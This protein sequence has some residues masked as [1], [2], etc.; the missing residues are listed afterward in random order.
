MALRAKSVAKRQ[1]RRKSEMRIHQTIA[2]ELGIAILTGIH[3]PGDHFPGEIE[4]AATLGVSRTAYREAIRILIAKG[5]LD[6]KPKSGTHITPQ[7][8]WNILDPD[9]L[10]WMFMG[11]P[12]EQFIHDLFELRS[13]LEPKAAELAAQRR[14][15]DQ[16]ELMRNAIED[17][18]LHGLATAEGQAA[19]LKFH[20]VLL[21]ATGN[22]AMASLA[23]SIGA[24]V[25]WTTDFKQRASSQARDSLSEHVA[26]FAAIEAGNTEAA[27]ATMTTLIQLA[28]EDMAFAL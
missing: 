9:M 20:S 22:A 18:R 27:R 15:A 24:A 16:L 5:L 23:S 11:K 26:V 19:D 7:E 25:Q 28:F 17:M 1:E 4:Q 21:A 13:L 2:Q 12:D 10:A 6:S 8:K 3:R 14:S